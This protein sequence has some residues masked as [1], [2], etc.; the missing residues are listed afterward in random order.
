MISWDFVVNGTPKV[1]PFVMNDING[2]R[3]LCDKPDSLLVYAN[4]MSFT[5][6]TT[7]LNMAVSTEQYAAFWDM[8]HG[9]SF[10]KQSQE[11]AFWWHEGIVENFAI[12]M[13]ATWMRLGFL[14]CVSLPSK[15]RYHMCNLDLFRQTVCV[16]KIFGGHQSFLLGH[17]YPCFGLDFKTRVDPSL[18][19]FIV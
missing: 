14:I 1:V 13:T 15:K 3:Q 11:C 10:A 16:G 8:S 6:L 19:Y 18:A 17:W 4:F 7:G 9:R 5:I 12:F 2:T